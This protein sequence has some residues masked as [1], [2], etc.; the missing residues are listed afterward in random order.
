MPPHHVTTPPLPRPAVSQIPQFTATRLPPVPPALPH[1][2]QVLLLHELGVT[3][4]SDEK[5]WTEISFMGTG[6][7]GGEAADDEGFG[8]EPAE[9]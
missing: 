1:M 3:A 4:R 5:W 9:K 2:A 7:A 6:G 8:L